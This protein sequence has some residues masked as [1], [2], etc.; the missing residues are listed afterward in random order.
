MSQPRK[1]RPWLAAIFIAIAILPVGIQI[2][3]LAHN[4]FL[5]DISA[6]YCAAR[7]ASHGADPYRT[8]PLRTCEQTITPGLLDHKHPTLAA[9][10]P[11]PGYA[12][13]AFVPLSV[14]PFP[15]AA[16]LWTV[17]LF[18][19]WF[20]CI[21][22]LVGF[23]GVSWEI[24]LLAFSL[25]L[26][27]TSIPLGQVA[28]IAVAA[29]CVSAYFAWQGR[30]HYAAI[31]AAI[32]MVEPH[33]GLPACIALAVWAPP[34]RL[35]LGA[36]FAALAVIS[37]LMLGPA[38]NLEYFT[39]VLPAHA[40]SEAA[41]DTQY[42]LTSVLVSMG[43][44]DTVAV[45]AG[46][47]WYLLMLASS[48]FVAGRLA[49]KTHNQAFLVCVPP[50]FA[51]FGGAFVHVTQIAA[52]IPA[53]LLIITYAKDYWRALAVV[54]LLLLVIPWKLAMSP[55]AALGPAVPIA[56]FAWHYWNRNIRAVV[57]AAIAC[58][59]L[60]MAIDHVNFSPSG[61]HPRPYYGTPIDPRLPEATWAAFSRTAWTASP[62]SWII[63]IPTWAGL[64]I[65][66]TTLSVGIPA[67]R[68]KNQPCL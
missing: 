21:K 44:I 39:N 23:A 41:R 7:V 59:L 68:V 49:R 27:A 37:L 64:L 33:L 50:A 25:S 13:A 32:A 15:A 29:L 31:A 1:S 9:P 26:A 60:Y 52:A 14:L 47:L 54:A 57:L 10:A 42:S 12:I 55:A 38:A 3:L 5:W 45:R 46:T 34:T 18:L 48:I 62:G 67:V 58:G 19:A 40:L 4:D 16:M 24:G 6:F 66:V 61:Q 20:A 8:E 43:A 35:W 11:L 51:V 30:W 53:A 28:P 56:Y 22:A 36:A 65:L 17:L 63:R 2:A